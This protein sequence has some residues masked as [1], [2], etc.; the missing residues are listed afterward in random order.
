MKPFSYIIH[1]FSQRDSYT[2]TAWKNLFSRLKYKTLIAF[3][4][5]DSH[6]LNCNFLG[7]R[8][9]TG[10]YV[11]PLFKFELYTLLIKHYQHEHKFRLLRM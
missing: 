9:F 11:I 8:E 3:T 10:Y 4:F 6:F 5:P 7:F 2:G 1:L